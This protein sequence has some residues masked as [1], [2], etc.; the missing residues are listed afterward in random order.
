MV[1]KRTQQLQ[2]QSVRHSRAGDVFHYRWAA[3]RCLKLI[4]PRSCLR[5]ITVE[6][7]KEPQLDGECSIDLAEYFEAEAQG[8]S[9]SYHQLKHS[10]A[11]QNKKL[12]F[13]EIRK[14][15]KDFASRHK[16]LLKQKCYSKITFSIVTNRQFSEAQK[17]L[18][19]AVKTKGKSK[20]GE[21]KRLE[22]YTGLNSKD[23]NEFLRSF[24]IVDGQGDYI[25]QK[26][27]LNG[28]LGEYLAGLVEGSEVNSV[29]N[30]VN[31][32]IMPD[33]DGNIHSEDVL[34]CL[35]VT[36]RQCLFPAPVE[37]E[38]LTNAI[39]R[40]QHNDILSK[41]LE[42][43][44][45]LIIHAA[46]G[47][48]KSV[49]ARQIATDL[50]NG[51]RGIVYDCFG[52]GKYR[53]PSEPRHKPS[54]A[55][56][57]MAN[58]L[59]SYGLCS[60]LIVSRNT[61]NEELFRSFIDR[62]RQA[63]TLIQEINKD[64]LLVLLVDA[65]DNAEM[66]AEESGDKCFAHAILRESFHPGCRV[67]AFCRT[68]RISLLQPQSYVRKYLLN[69]FSGNE[70][71]KHFRQFYANATD[72]ECLQL[73]R[74]TRGNPRVQ[75]NALASNCKSSV[76]VLATLDPSK[77]TTVDAQIARQLQAAINNIKDK[78][79][80][81]FGK[82]VDAIC[83]GLSN[84]PPFVPIEVLASAANVEV[85][86]IESFV[87][88]LGRPLWHWDNSVQFRDEPTET[89]FHQEF[90][91][92]SQEV[93][94]YIKAIEPL[95]S[96]Y[97]YVAK[98]LPQLLL[99]S[100]N[101]DRLIKLALSDECL[102]DNNP[103]DERSIRVYRLQFAFKAA[104]KKGRMSD[105]AQIAF[106]AGEE[107]A[108][109]DRQAE[110]LGKNFDL[111][112]VLQGEQRVREIA[113]QHAIKCAWQGSENVYSAA[114]LSTVP[115][116]KGEA[117]AYL[118]SAQRW[119]EIH[120]EERDR[121]KENPAFERN[122]LKDDDIGEIAFTHFNLSG[123]K[124]FVDYTAK[125][126]PPVVGFNIT[127]LVIGR[128][129]D[130]EKY[131]DIDKIV[132][133]SSSN[134]YALLAITS[135]LA[136]LGQF[137]S[138]R[139]LT[140]VLNLLCDEA[141]RIPKSSPSHE[142]D[143]FT[144]SILTFVEACAAS[145]L[146]RSK[147]L[148]VLEYYNL[149]VTKVSIVHDYRTYE[150]NIF[151]RR[152]A[153][154]GALT[155]KYEPDFKEMLGSGEAISTQK[156]NVSEE[157]HN[158]EKIIGALW[159]LYMAR[160]R[161]LIRDAKASNFDVSQI[162]SQAISA[163]SQRYQSQDLAPYE[164]TRAYFD[165][166]MFKAAPSVKELSDF[167]SKIIK[168]KNSEFSIKDRLHALYVVSR[169]EHLSSLRD[170]LEE[171]C[172]ST[173]QDAASE[174]PEER[175]EWYV[176]LARAVISK[177]TADA[178]AYFNTAVEAL[179]KFGGEMIQRWDA[180]TAIARR[181]GEGDKCEQR[182]AYRYIRCGEMIG[183][184]V[185]REKYWDRDEVF[186]VAVR[187]NP[188]AA[189][190][191]LSRWRDRDIGWFSDHIKALVL[192]SLRLKII[193]PALAWCFS[194]FVG[195]NASIKHAESCIRLETSKNKQQHILECAIK[196]FQLANA[197][198]QDLDAL[199]SVATECKLQTRKI[200]EVAKESV[201]AEYE[202]NASI[203]QFS[204][205]NEAVKRSSLEYAK[206]L[207]QINVFDPDELK[208]A[209]LAMYS[210]DFPREFSDNWRDIIKKVPLGKECKFLDMIADFEGLDHHAASYAIPVIS[211]WKEKISVKQIWSQFL[212]K[213]GKRLALTLS[214]RHNLSFW[215][216]MCGL[217]DD[218]ATVIKA[219][220]T[221]GLSESPELVSAEAFFGFISNTANLLSPTEARVLLDYALCRFELYVDDNF[222]DGPWEAW[223]SSPDNI[224]DAVCGLIWS[225]LGS[226]YATMRWQAVHCV[227]RL[228]E[229]SCAPEI[230]SLVKWMRT[231]GVG[232]FG[233]KK[234]PFYELHSTLYLLIAFARAALDDCSL[235]KRHALLFSDIALKGVPHALI[236]V[237]SARIALSIESKFPATYSRK[238]VTELKKVGT[239]TLQP[240]VVDPYRY[241][242]DRTW[243]ADPGLKLKFDWDFDHYWF[244]QFGPVFGVYEDQV[245]ELAGQMAVNHLKI[246]ENKEWVDDPRQNLWK[247]LNHRDQST[248]HSHG[249]YPYIDC[250]RFYYSYHAFLSVAA[251]LLK[252]LPV[253]RHINDPE[254][255]NAWTDWLQRHLLT[256][257]D[258]KWLADRRDPTP[259]AHAKWSKGI[260]EDEW[261]T[262]LS[263]DYFLKMLLEQCPMP[264]S[265]CVRASWSNCHND[266][267]E[268]VSIA[269]ALVNPSA[270]Q[271]LANALSYCK[272]PR[273][274]R[275]PSYLD[276]E[277][278]YKCPPFE[279]TGWIKTRGMD[280][281]RDEFD[282]FA[283]NIHYP[284][285]EVGQPFAE[286]LKL[287]TDSDEERYWYM[288]GVEGRV[289]T[290][291]VW[292]DQKIGQR[293]DWPY[294]YGEK[295]CA[296]EDFLKRLCAAQN[297]HLIFEVQVRRSRHHSYYRGGAKDNS[298]D[299]PPSHKIF[300]FSS[301]GVLKDAEKSYNVG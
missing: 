47:V 81:R 264:R 70:T 15:L 42:C 215:L 294:R 94:K 167:N 88:D 245:T 17:R 132:H 209:I 8:T 96:T 147:I 130:A 176:A 295:I 262:T 72:C 123:S 271:S 213:I 230:A 208:R 11:R 148:S 143:S 255:E 79:P 228:C 202:N 129:L 138:K 184:N 187:L 180:V 53:N 58:E 76:A 60:P 284:P 182:L 285:S 18:L 104:L 144:A 14:T 183:E 71:A 277:M 100:G 23:L 106:R 289:L 178:T 10:S 250:F 126:K 133:L 110:L 74:L 197:A 199:M 246:V 225:A 92:N 131:A 156:S 78:Q 105:A 259:A 7:S 244:T 4:D 119:L 301:D 211:V 59:A 236:Q 134:P 154:R 37:F 214:D 9:V 161:I 32:K 258:G 99:R 217:N 203:R 286:S 263:A 165:I 206:F 223:L 142:L 54:N 222:A 278:E 30:L 35:G 120:L 268:Y 257:T 3:R 247:N 189:Y 240:L 269:S 19:D 267:V 69:P 299:I 288:P 242:T 253:I 103:I 260:K 65:A 265:I 145:G 24:L 300:I 174:T 51:S 274:F 86:T 227:R 62:V 28:E 210:T 266:L 216:Q 45:P 139:S 49:V 87:S 107:S 218:E 193:N 135:E 6:L 83:K 109:N 201:S 177:S 194:G 160:A 63:V 251:K 116:F 192:E 48:G 152:A 108:G 93:A 31:E 73:H 252:E 82:Q 38:K 66:A 298:L 275:L 188:S 280:K 172:R 181:A 127:R 219:G 163:L 283:R 273:N 281:G 122:L 276:N 2:S 220:I 224:P 186:R 205:E 111:I 36:S 43:A 25:A 233:S 128:L 151:L 50:P 52:A 64:A 68:E 166:L 238:S 261:L 173:L 13:G 85:A 248:S 115:A 41:I 175:A 118:K 164:A 112:H 171:S 26:K 254:G 55:L 146:S 256:R 46:G 279:L 282:P 296:N 149:P 150:R 56:V 159:P 124:A 61:S 40:E 168:R 44:S 196:D 90:A 57:Q 170:D 121:N 290:N 125:W 22:N 95:S 235:L 241:K 39:Q 293:E 1:T 195:C 169:Q 239:S 27:R 137:P 114:L 75:A 207:N 190:S 287:F 157:D 33:S 117:F 141:K 272:D 84:L 162:H 77:V 34:N 234:F 155:G 198:K 158:F 136:A 113:R 226:P 140:I 21:L 153:L 237:T 102:P 231:G 191:A 200:M 101:Y 243:Q 179:A 297:K 98:A 204:P 185:V 212:N 292:S 29:I 291:E 221:K 67:I 20:A 91:A 270:S 12:T 89:W 97:A 80:L 5:G 232:P 16:Q 249:S 229:Y